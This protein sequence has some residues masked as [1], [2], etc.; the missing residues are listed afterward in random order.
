MQILEMS[1]DCVIVLQNTSSSEDEEK[2]ICCI[3]LSR[4]DSIDKFFSPFNCKGSIGVM[5]SSCFK[6]YLLSKTAQESPSLACELCGFEHNTRL[7]LKKSFSWKTLLRKNKNSRVVSSVINLLNILLTAFFEICM[8]LIVKTDAKNPRYL[9]YSSFTSWNSYIFAKGVLILWV[10]STWDLLKELYLNEIFILEPDL[11][12][13]LA[14][15]TI[16]I[17]LNSLLKVDNDPKNKK[18]FVDFA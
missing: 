11:E 1:R 5:H 8:A 3:S 16:S 10:H 13:F 7:K 12:V 9:N 6:D 2:D 15:E 4:P 18:Y 17:C 14:N